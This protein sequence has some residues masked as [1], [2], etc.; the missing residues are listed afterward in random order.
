MQVTVS[1]A[2]RF[3][4]QEKLCCIFYQLLILL[5]FRNILPVSEHPHFNLK[6]VNYKIYD[7]KNMKKVIAT[8]HFRK[9]PQV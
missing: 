3:D 4:F 7:A 5:P 2:T 6:M 9:I 8:T 1:C